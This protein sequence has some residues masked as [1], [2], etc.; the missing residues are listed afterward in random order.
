MRF[1]VA[2]SILAV[3]LGVSVQPSDAQ[4]PVRIEDR[5]WATL[6]RII[7][8]P[9]GSLSS[10][11]RMLR[12]HFAQ[13]D[14]TGD[15]YNERDAEIPTLREAAKRR[16]TVIAAWLRHDLDGNGQ[17]DV[18]EARESLTFDA[19]QPIPT[20]A[21]RTA[22]N[23][24]LAAEVLDQLLED[25]DLPDPNGDGVTTFDEMRAAAAQK[26]PPDGNG[27][28]RRGG[29][30][31]V[32]DS[33]FDADGDGTVTETEFMAAVFP[34]LVTIDTDGD[35]TV[36]EDERTAA[37]K[38]AEA[39][40]KRVARAKVSARET[41]RAAT[42]ASQCQGAPTVPNHMVF[43]TLGIDEGLAVPTVVLESTRT[44]TLAD[45]R[46][47]NGWQPIFLVVSAGEPLI[48][49][50][51]G[52]V[53][54]IATVY[55]IGAATGHV[56]LATATRTLTAAPGCILAAQAM[57]GATGNRYFHELAGRS[58]D[59]R[60]YIGRAG[61]VDVPR[62]R[63]QPRHGFSGAVSL[64]L[65]GEAAPLWRRFL[66]LRPGGLVRLVANDVV[67]KVSV[68]EP[69]Q[70]AGAAGLA[71]LVERG[72]LSVLDP[73]KLE[74]RKSADDGSIKLRNLEI[75]LGRGDQLTIEG[76]SWQLGADGQYHG[77]PLPRLEI[78]KKFSLPTGLRGIENA[79]LVLPEGMPEPTGA[80][81]TATIERR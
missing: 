76:E 75:T 66:T 2:V 79:V 1:V 42:A 49:R 21:G 62:L 37:M 60:G 20:A 11:N 43:V 81:G 7:N 56:G 44:T 52:A 14:V 8:T 40:M 68:S 39:A 10:Y 12:F 25:L 72:A 73:G 53:E 74:T 23:D 18:G 28:G 71:T 51:S 30:S 27:G 16:Q 33:A 35:G 34:V 77:G 64:S 78:R 4:E 9:K 61:L 38:I 55:S 22:V 45:I 54:R 70:P 80:T 50:Y 17:L 69:A 6:A 57:S 32:I 29:R 67:S 36:T 63:N 5:A 59:A 48:L 15:G 47:E 41:S 26:H 31:V 58:P 24:A 3:G 19:R 46:I 13:A 65:E